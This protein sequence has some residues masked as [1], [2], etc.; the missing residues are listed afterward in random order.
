M[1]A[2]PPA[3][4]SFAIL[5]QPSSFIQAVIC[6]PEFTA[7]IVLGAT[8]T[9]LFPGLLTTAKASAALTVPACLNARSQ[10]CKGTHIRGFY[11]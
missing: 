1:V 5:Y 11:N 2:D 10:S 4:F 8:C 9:C 7:S 6:T 3:L